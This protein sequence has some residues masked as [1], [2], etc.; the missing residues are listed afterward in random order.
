MNRGLLNARQTKYAAYA[1]LYVIVILAIVSVANVL[2][3][4]YNKSYDSTANKRY[5]LSDQ[6]AKIVKGLKQNASINYYD[7]QSGFQQAKD[8]L[9]RYSTLSPKVR[10]EYIDVEKRPQEARA[11]GITKLGTSLVQIG[12]KKEE[13]KSVTESEITGAIIRDLKTS[14]RTVCFVTG[15]GEHQLDDTQRNG[16]SRLKDI[17]AKDQYT[18]KSI[19]LLEK[20][21]IPA[22][23]TVVVIGGPQ[24]EYVQP[25]VD[26]LKKYV[27]QGGRAMIMLDAPLKFG[28]PT[29]DNAALSDLLQSW[30]VSLDKDLLL[31]L[32]PVGQLM[33]L[34]PEVALVSTY[35]SHPIVDEMKGTATGFPLS[36]SLTI[37][38]T[39]KTTVQKLFQ[40]SATSLATSKL[41]S[42]NVN[43]SDPNNKKGPLT[44]GA[45]GSYKTGKENSEGR[46]VVVGSSS[47]PANSFINFNGNG[48]LAL[49]ALNWLASDEDL[50]SIRP[51]EQENRNVTMTR[52]QFNWVRLS[53]QFL[54]PGALLLAGVSVWWRR[55]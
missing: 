46:F 12:T 35:D 16:F 5:S 22:D 31:D 38:N 30:G 39:D 9:D 23:C 42:P 25:A 8:I 34:G 3:N 37:K 26:A 48:D 43:P 15:S 18:T 11:A 54:L 21:E 49:N 44:I 51:K 28:H 53:S 36:R 4:R 55:R 19:S 29:A 20:A 24:S 40:S 47:W 13:A 27:E 33:G 10:V 50:I 45:A 14:T 1:A 7:R 6:T 32:S 2:A 52:A 17:L 41:D